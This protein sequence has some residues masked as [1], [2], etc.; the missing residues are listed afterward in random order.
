MSPRQVFSLEFR[1]R[2]PLGL[3]FAQYGLETFEVVRFRQK[4]EISVAAEFGSAVHHARLAAHQQRLNLRPL[5]RRKDS[6]YRVRDQENLPTQETPA[7][8]SGFRLIAPTG[9][10]DTN[11]AIR[12]GKYLPRSAIRCRIGEHGHAGPNPPL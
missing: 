2:N 5:D 11:R 3:K 9:L 12:P 1:D 8:F 7:T 10:G 6:E 4:D